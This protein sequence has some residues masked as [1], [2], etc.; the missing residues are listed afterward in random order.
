[1]N[2]E[3]RLR[4]LIIIISA[5]F[6][7]IGGFLMLTRGNPLDKAI[8]KVIITN[9]IERMEVKGYKYSYNNKNESDILENFI[10]ITDAQ[11]IPEIDYYPDSEN[12]IAV[13][14]SD[15]Y[16]GNLSYTVYDSDFNIMIEN[17]PNLTMPGES[18]KKY[19]I[20]IGVN[21]GEDEKNIT[22]KYYFAINIVE[23]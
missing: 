19:Y 5:A 21:W 4:K 6:A 3:E 2:K 10:P 9:G 22:V 14:Y 7:V 11:N 20:E 12:N 23:K 18:G 17:Q 15:K 8:G 13:S 16:T 1:M